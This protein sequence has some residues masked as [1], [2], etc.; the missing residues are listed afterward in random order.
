MS[1]TG[2]IL[3]F[4]A[5]VF[6]AAVVS[7]LFRRSRREPLAVGAGFLIVLLSCYPL[8]RP[9]GGRLS[10]FAHAVWVTVI[11]AAFTFAYAKLSRK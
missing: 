3:T 11:A 5:G 8:T 6:A 9:Y 1:V 7:W 4:V 10:F 2:S